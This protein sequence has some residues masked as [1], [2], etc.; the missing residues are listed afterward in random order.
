[1]NTEQRLEFCIKRLQCGLSLAQR[2]FINKGLWDSRNCKENQLGFFTA[3]SYERQEKK[4]AVKC[5]EFKQMKGNTWSTMCGTERYH[6]HFE[7]SSFAFDFSGTEISPQVMSR[8][9]SV[10]KGN[11]MQKRQQP[12][13]QN[14]SQDDPLTG[15]DTSAVGWGP[16]YIHGN[17]SDTCSWCLLEV[18][19]GNRGATE[20]IYLGQL[21]SFVENQDVSGTVADTGAEPSFPQII[22]CIQRFGF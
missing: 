6:E 16:G 20:F 17:L 8:W 21:F 12:L 19:K 22:F 10:V 14:G 3:F 18:G 11:S 5:R 7:V 13:L 1:M 2:G 9:K 15:R 4:N